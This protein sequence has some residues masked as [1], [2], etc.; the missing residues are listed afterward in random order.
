MKT[1]TKESLIDELKKIRDKGWIKSKRPGN[2]G[3]VGNTLED[4]L[5]IDENNLPI[6][7]AA[8]WEL[9]AQKT[10]ETSLLT[11]FH[12]EPSPRAL[13][14]IPRILLPIYGWK[15]KD[16]GTKYQKDEKSFRQTIRAT[17]ISDRGFYVK[18]ERNNKKISID[19][20]INKI[21]TRHNDWKNAVINNGGEILK[22][23]PYWGFHDLYHK[24]GT[25][26]FNCFFVKAESKIENRVEYFKF[27]EILMLKN[28]SNE[29]IIKNIEHGNIY[30]DFDARTGHNHGTK[31]RIKQGCIP[32]LYAESQHY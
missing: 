20:D 11:L 6:P 15:H 24:A 27:S 16:A 7:N 10:N 8:E 21:D 14:F 25:K 30:I 2:D 18:I 32:D 22:E 28:L 31:F 12:M 19:F 9:K 13:K 5:E 4:L 23:K 1:Y 17:T 26:L 3:A 29:N